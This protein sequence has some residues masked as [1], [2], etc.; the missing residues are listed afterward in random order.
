M[1][2]GNRRND[3]AQFIDTV[4]RRVT[5]SF[6]GLCFELKYTTNRRG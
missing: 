6:F 3:A 5:I 2:A 4:I 1:S